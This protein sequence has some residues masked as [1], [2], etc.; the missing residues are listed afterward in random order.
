MIRRALTPKLLSLAKQFPIIVLTGPRQSGKTTLAKATFKGYTYV[1]LENL[2]NR[3]FAVRDP[4]G[5]LAKYKK[6]TI[7]DEAQ[8]APNILSY[9]QTVVDEDSS[10]GRYILTGSQQFNLLAGVSQSLA[11]RAAYL[12]LLPFSLSELSGS[13]SLDPFVL[14][15]PDN[16]PAP[17]FLQLFHK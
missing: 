1:S 8:R 4:R 15:K 10:P 3:E 11:G 7:I 5:F 2:D 12:R 17:S 13:K 14:S 6:R 16:R 9:I